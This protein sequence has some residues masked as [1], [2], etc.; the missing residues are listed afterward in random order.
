MKQ[1]SLRRCITLICVV[2]LLIFGI[3]ISILY[4]FYRQSNIDQNKNLT[5]SLAK[6]YS[7]LVDN[8][9]ND[10]HTTALNASSISYVQKYLLTMTSLQKLNAY[11]VLTVSLNLLARS[12]V[13]CRSIFVRSENLSLLRSTSDFFVY[14]SA[15]M[16]DYNMWSSSPPSASFFAGPYHAPGDIDLMCYVYTRMAEYDLR[17]KASEGASNIVTIILFNPM[18]LLR[19]GK[20]DPHTV[21]G[22]IFN[23]TLFSSPGDLPEELADRISSQSN[24]EV[25]AVTYRGEEYYLSRMALQGHPDF[26]YFCLIRIGDETDRM[27]DIRRFT[28]AVLVGSVFLILVLLFLTRQWVAKPITLLVESLRAVTPETT[29]VACTNLTEFNDVVTAIR[30]ML[31]NLRESRGRALDAQRNA[32]EAELSHMIAEM[33]F[34]RAQIN[35]HFLFNT[36]GCISAMARDC[37]TQS[38]EK[39]CMALA[40]MCRYAMRSPLFVTLEQDIANTSNYMQIMAVRMPGK[41]DWRVRADGEASRL[42]VLSLTLQPLVENCVEHGFKNFRKKASCVIDLLAQVKD[43]ALW[44]RLTD[45]G[46]GMTEEAVRN[47]YKNMTADLSYQNEHIGLNNLWHRLRLAYGDQCRMSFR[48]QKGFYTQVNIEIPLTP[49]ASAPFSGD[50]SRATD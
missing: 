49:A 5:I 31:E 10:I 36:L 47:V 30:S 27:S 37:E 3:I 12:T 23:G 9:L 1:Y 50:S 22:L 16:N 48:A 40:E 13:G 8:N 33:K 6:T 28:S 44:I 20:G 42:P 25:V 24:D 15:L 7:E 19:S 2:P 43:G 18:S 46:D 34:Y 39:S 14:Y 26:D 4:R 29:Y 17:V 32:Y 45:N 38:I 35:P 11:P 41:Y 21:E